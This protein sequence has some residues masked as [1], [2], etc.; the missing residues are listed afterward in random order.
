LAYRNIRLN[1]IQRFLYFLLRVVSWTGFRVFYRKRL[2]LHR[3]NLR[4]DGP[5]IVICNHPSTLTDVLNVGIP[6]R[7]EMFFLANYSLFK[8]PL[9]N[10]LFTR[11]FCIPIKRKEDMAEG[12]TRNNEQAFRQ[13]FHHLEQYGVLFIAPEGVSWTN[14][15]VRPFKTG[16]ARIACG[17]ESENVWKLDLKIIPVG[18]SYSDSQKFRSEVVVQAGDPIYPREWKAQWE[19][20]PEA[21]YDDLTAALETRVKE[22]T[23]HCRDEAGEQLIARLEI[24]LQN[25][26][27]LSQEE[28]FYRSQ[29]LT[30]TCLDNTHLH[31]LVNQYFKD[32][33]DNGLAD[34]GMASADSGNVQ[35]QFVR[36]GFRMALGFPFF[37]LG[38][39]CWFLPCYLPALLAKKLNLYLGYHSTV[40]ILAGMIVFPI[41]FTAVFKLIRYSSGDHLLAWTVLCVI[42]LLGFATERF[43]DVR[44]R[45]RNTQRA[46]KWA[47]K[48]QDTFQKLTQ[49]RR[50]ILAICRDI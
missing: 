5:A 35:A 45:F 14:R 9:T 48:N 26:V 38:Y 10:W 16:T 49:L 32:L 20:D 1:F 6:I 21:A 24:M 31:E 37:L 3:K 12:E 50:K 19:R 8:T 7:Q 47:L 39:A 43:M 17:V 40:K 33:S 30:H 22:L 28:S 27:T 2:V 11:L 25:E 4:F 15:F 36:D 44:N 42:I 13:S 29:R 34:Q 18:L 23:I 41:Y 46:M